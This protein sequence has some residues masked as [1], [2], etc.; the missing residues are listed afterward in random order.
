MAR[1]DIAGKGATVSRNDLVDDPKPIGAYVVLNRKT[2]VDV[3]LRGRCGPRVR[4]V[5]TIAPMF[6]L[7]QQTPFKLPVDQFPNGLVCEGRLSVVLDCCDFCQRECND[8][9]VHKPM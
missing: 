8:P 1:A 7:V 6:Q 5:N 3:M 9:N 2:E 4:I